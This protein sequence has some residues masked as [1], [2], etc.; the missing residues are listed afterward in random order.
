MN[1]SAPDAVLDEMLIKVATATRMSICS[2][3]P[4]NFAGIAAVSLADVV[5]TPGDGNDYTIADG[6]VSG[7]KVTMVQKSGVVID[8]T[9]NG[10]HI[11]LDNGVDLIWVTTMAP[12]SLVAAESTIIPAWKVESRDPT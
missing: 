8:N 3:H 4:V 7:R 5:M 1:K 12:E 9:G 6:D 11:V 2:D 10:N